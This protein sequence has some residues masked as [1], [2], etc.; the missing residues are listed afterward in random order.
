MVL[1]PAELAHNKANLW[2]VVFVTSVADYGFRSLR[3]VG[4]ILERLIY[5]A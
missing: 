4:H 2:F 5:Y 3:Y 1:S